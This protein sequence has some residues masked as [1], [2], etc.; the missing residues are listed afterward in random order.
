MSTHDTSMPRAGEATHFCTDCGTALTGTPFC[1]GC[2]A[3]VDSPAA[4]GPFPRHAA[5]TQK[6]A[7]A[8]GAS[9]PPVDF[10]DEV[11]ATAR[12][13]D[14]GASGKPS[15]AQ[16]APRRRWPIVVACGLLAVAAVAAALIVVL[17]GSSSSGGGDQHAAYLQKMSAAFAPV[18]RAN[19]HLSN[20]LD[21]LS[22]GHPAGAQ[23]AVARAQSATS[24]AR[25]ALGAL[26]VPAGSEQVT[27]RLRQALDREDTYLGA[28]STALAH[29]SSPGVAQLQTL[30]GNLT[31]ALEGVGAPIDATAQS[32]GGADAVTAWAVSARHAAARRHR[33]ASQSGAA[34]A[35]SAPATP[36]PY[37]NGRDCGDGIHA[38]PNTS[39]E[40]AA[41]VRAAYDEAPGAAATVDVYSPVTGKTY[42]MDCRPAGS[43]TTCSGGNGASASW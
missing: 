11:E 14:A 28:V 37:A 36:G 10:L 25:G 2:G 21:G 5:A 9:L 39:C 23:A 27:T 19:Q 1:P 17:G 43:G 35:A 31:N 32:V 22:A 33:Q 38:G 20:E 34:G 3:A 7:R 15:P 6:A 8:A 18:D 41:N 29:P 13:G 4:A 16:P 40:F 30:E 26:S 42:S 24:E 12:L